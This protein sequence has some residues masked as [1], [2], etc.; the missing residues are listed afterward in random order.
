MDHRSHQWDREVQLQ[1]LGLV[2]QQSRN[3]VASLNPEVGKPAGE[4]AG[5]RRTTSP[6]D[7]PIAGT[8]RGDERQ[9]RRV[10][11]SRSARSTSD[12]ERQREVVHHETVQH[13]F[14]TVQHRHR[15]GRIDHR[16]A[17]P[18]CQQT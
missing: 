3:P 13:G 15:A 9:P 16:S 6:K 12:G 18:L 14:L 8:R 11:V 17:R 10:G 5:A 1:V 7:G 2:P 4:S